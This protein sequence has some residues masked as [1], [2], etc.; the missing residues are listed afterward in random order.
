MNEKIIEGLSAQFSQ[1]MNTF[2]GS[3][4]LPGQQQVKV[5]L[6]SALSKMDLV[7]RDEFDAQAAVLGRTREK[8]EQME[9][10]L[11]ELESRIN[12]QENTSKKD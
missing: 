4:E 3:A 5:F 8:V 12:S 11:A 9:K 10:V 6:Q 2:N 1:M 7:T